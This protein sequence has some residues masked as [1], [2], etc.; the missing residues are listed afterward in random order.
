MSYASCRGLNDGTRGWTEG[1]SG[2]NGTQ[3]HWNSTLGYLSASTAAAFEYDYGIGAAFSWLDRQ[4]GYNTTCSN[5]AEADD[6]ST[7]AS[8]WMNWRV[9]ANVSYLVATCYIS[10]LTVI[11]LVMIM[12]SRTPL[13]LI[14]CGCTVLGLSIAILGFLQNQLHFARNWFWLWNFIAETIGM[15]ALTFTIVTVGSGFYPISCKRNK[16]WKL[17]VFLIVL[18]ALVATANIIGYLQQKVIHHNISGSQ[19]TRLKEDVLGSGMRTQKALCEE[20]T[21]AQCMHLIPQGNLTL[22]GVDN[23]S[24]LPWSLRDV[25]VRPVWW[26][27]VTN[28]LLMVLT[29]TWASIYLFVPLLMHHRSRPDMV[30][31]P[32]DSDMMAVGVWYLSCVMTLAVVST[33]PTSDF[34]AP[35]DKDGLLIHFTFCYA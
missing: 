13:R 30:D 18:Y 25:F 6:T 29:I 14:A 1:H 7:S 28:Q 11:A 23:W 21:W 10:F 27:Y 2:L 17:S 31:R 35:A 34:I 5:M 19:F 8:W 16:F 26:A 12:R 33:R 20:V 15:V 24:L 9:S 4:R 3:P 32:I 22:T